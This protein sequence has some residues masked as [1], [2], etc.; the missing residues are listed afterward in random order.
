MQQNCGPSIFAAQVVLG[1]DPHSVRIA[2]IELISE[3]CCNCT[4][5][6]EEQLGLSQA[7]LM[8][9]FQLFKQS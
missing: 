1:A 4:T 6:A 2:G 5:N 3:H 9:H 8:I 7:R